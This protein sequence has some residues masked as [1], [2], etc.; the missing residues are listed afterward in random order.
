MAA[1]HPPNTLEG[2]GRM[3]GSLCRYSG[4]TLF[5]FLFWGFILKAAKGY[6]WYDEVTGEPSY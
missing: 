2:D 4:S 1:A 3:G 5:P 6:L